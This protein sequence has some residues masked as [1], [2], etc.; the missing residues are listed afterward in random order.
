MQKIQDIFLATPKAKLQV[1]VLACTC[2]NGYVIPPFVIFDRKTLNPELTKGE[3]PGTLYGLSSNGWIDMELFSA[4]FFD[5]FLKYVPMFRPLLLL[6]DGHASHYCPEVI[7]MAAKE[8]VIIFTLPPNTTHLTQPLDRAC[9][10]PLKVHWRQAVQAF[11]AVNHRP[12]TRFD[13]SSLFSETWVNAM[14][15]KNVIS[16]FRVCGIHPFNRE[17]LVN[18][19]G[20]EA[21]IMRVTTHAE[22]IRRFSTARA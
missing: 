12:I 11:V 10:S 4:W 9:F 13:F 22:I 19:C 8:K 18:T 21:E 3:V 1:T 14:S 6:L 5:H 20:A 2:A 17:A 16:G 7:K 15:M